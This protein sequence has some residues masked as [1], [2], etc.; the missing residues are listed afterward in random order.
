MAE[1]WLVTGASGQLG[2]HVQR[3][4]ATDARVGE[5]CALVRAGAADSAGG[6]NQRGRI[7]RHLHDT[8]RVPQ[9]GGRS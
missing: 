2:G 1:R 5:L 3:S 7:Q 8:R 9:S 4:L 6:R